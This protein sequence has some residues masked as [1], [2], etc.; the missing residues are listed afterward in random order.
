MEKFK[1]AKKVENAIVSCVLLFV[2]TLVVA[3]VSFITLGNARK[4]DAN[5]DSMIA[6]LQAQEQALEQGIEYV[7]TEEYLQEQAIDSFGMIKDGD[8]VYIF[9][10]TKK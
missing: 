1:E 6:K 3:I 2:V 4:K 9:D 5:Y 8:K 10:Y 7:Q